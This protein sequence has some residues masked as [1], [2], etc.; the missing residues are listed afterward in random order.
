ML[1]FSGTVI[2]KNVQIFEKLDLPQ[3]RHTIQIIGYDK[4][5]EKTFDLLSIKG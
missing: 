1:T 3:G 2:Q 5:T 4:S